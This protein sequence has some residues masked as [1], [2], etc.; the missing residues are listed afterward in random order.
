MRRLR[1]AACRARATMRFETVPGQQTQVNFGQCRVWL[2]DNG[3][4]AHLFVIHVRLL[5]PDVPR[6]LPARAGSRPCS[7]ATS[8]RS[9]TS[10]ACRRR[11][12]STMRSQSCCD[13]PAKRRRGATAWCGTRPMLTSRR[14]TASRPGPTGSTAAD[15]GRGRVRGEGRAAQRALRETLPV[16]GA[17]ERVT[18]RVGDDGGRHAGARDDPR[19]LAPVLRGSSSP[20]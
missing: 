3:V 6:G 17:L 20:R 5:A 9:S 18:A 1:S 16:V 15:E 4:T 2:G 19:G 7:R 13:T 14:S 10:A 12:S 11:S 8:T